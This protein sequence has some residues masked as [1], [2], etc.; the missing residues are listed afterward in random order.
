MNG[1]R[2]LQQPKNQNF[3][4]P[5]YK[6]SCQNEHKET[7]WDFMTVEKLFLPSV[8]KILKNF[9]QNIKID[10]IRYHFSM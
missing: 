7:L 10:H 8:S 5:I 3:K 4:D 1:R 6:I 9:I 2:K